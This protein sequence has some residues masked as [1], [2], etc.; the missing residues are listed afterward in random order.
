[1]AAKRATIVVQED[2]QV[3]RKKQRQ[4]IEMARANGIWPGALE[5]RG[6][7]GVAITVFMPEGGEEMA[8]VSA[9]E[10]A[11]SQSCSLIP[12]N[13]GRKIAEGVKEN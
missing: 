13:I 7:P 12:E 9:T 1:M 8:Q 6:G 3:E 10:R 2:N 5:R 4:G 11:Q